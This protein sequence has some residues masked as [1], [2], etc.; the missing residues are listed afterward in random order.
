MTPNDA[1]V[2]TG[3]PNTSGQSTQLCVTFTD[4]HAG[5][6]LHL[7]CTSQDHAEILLACITDLQRQ[8][9][10][11]VDGRIQSRTVVCGPWRDHTP[12]TS[13]PPSPPRPG[14]LNYPPGLWCTDCARTCTGD[15]PCPCCAGERK[16]A[17]C[18]TRGPQ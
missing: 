11:R 16:T 5:A 18:P 14:H 17:V 2:L 3:L 15:Q 7:P 1:D 13:P 10:V 12:D 9:H 4:T 8:H 6:E